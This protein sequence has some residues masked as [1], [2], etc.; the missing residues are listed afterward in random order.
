MIHIIAGFLRQIQQ[1]LIPAAWLLIALGVHCDN[2]ELAP[3]LKPA[4]RDLSSSILGYRAALGFSCSDTSFSCPQ[5]D[6]A[7]R[8]GMQEVSGS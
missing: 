8:S 5:S 1:Q 4:L 3:V 2:R 7:I 6:H